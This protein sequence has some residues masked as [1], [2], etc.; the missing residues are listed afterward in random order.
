[1]TF[2]VCQVVAVSIGIQLV[3]MTVTLDLWSSVRIIRSQHPHSYV[4]MQM[5]HS[6]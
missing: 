3:L 4:E 5:I 6:S 1:M 2:S